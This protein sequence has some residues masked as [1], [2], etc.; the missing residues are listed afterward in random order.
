MNILSFT[1]SSFITLCSDHEK[2]KRIKL[3]ISK[4][5]FLFRFFKWAIY[6]SLE[7]FFSGCLCFFGDFYFEPCKCFFISLDLFGLEAGSVRR[8]DG[9]VFLSFDFYR[10]FSSSRLGEKG[11]CLISGEESTGL[12]SGMEGGS[13][14]FCSLSILE[15]LSKSASSCGSSE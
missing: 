13:S 11:S 9:R 12:R 4:Y 15:C 2:D 1:I 14:I 6:Y 7:S 10:C 3:H 5:H 8:W